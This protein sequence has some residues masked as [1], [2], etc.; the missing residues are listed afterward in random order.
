MGILIKTASFLGKGLSQMRK[1][2]M[3][4]ISKMGKSMA[5]AFFTIIQD[6]NLLEITNMAESKEKERY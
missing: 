3:K 1:V 5:R 4:G 2:C 6:A